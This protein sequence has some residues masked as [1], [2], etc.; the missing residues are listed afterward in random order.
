MFEIETKQRRTYD[1]SASTWVGE[2]KRDDDDEEEEG[3]D[4]DDDDDEASEEEAS[5][6]INQV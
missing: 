3:D 6:V 2:A 5:L 1:F 4:D